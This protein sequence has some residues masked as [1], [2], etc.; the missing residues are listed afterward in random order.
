MNTYV[1]IFLDIDARGGRK[2]RTDTH[3]RGTATVTITI[4]IIRS[5]E[6]QYRYTHTKT[7]N[8][9]HMHQSEIII[10]RNALR[11]SKH[12]TESIRNIA[13]GIGIN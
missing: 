11:V 13:R 10:K 3:T 6:A 5:D 7:L 8:I 9:K 4:K 12:V 2:L 1:P